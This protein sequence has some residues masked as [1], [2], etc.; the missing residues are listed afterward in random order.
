MIKDHTT[1]TYRDKMLLI[2]HRGNLKGP[3]D[4]ENH[5]D[6]ISDAIKSGFDVEIDVWFIDKEYFLGHDVPQYKINLEFLK[7]DRL[8]CHAKNSDALYKMIENSV[9]CFWHDKDDATITSKGHIWCN[10]EKY[11]V[12]SIMVDFGKPRN[13]NNTGIKGICTDIPLL[14]KEKNV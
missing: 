5:P 1:L 12:N 4:L 14:W 7:N 13:L 11:F 8:W 3:S 9:H 10:P 2:S 6:Y